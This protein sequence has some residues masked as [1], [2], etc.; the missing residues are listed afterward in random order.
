YAGH[1][2]HPDR[3]AAIRAA[4]TYAV[5]HPDEQIVVRP[6]QFRFAG[7][8]GMEIP[9]P[10]FNDIMERLQET[11]GLEGEQLREAMQGVIRPTSRRRWAGFKQQRKGVEGYS[12]DLD[13][14]MRAHLGEVVRYVYMDKIKYEAVTL[15]ERLGLT[16]DNRQ[17]KGLSAA[18]EAYVR[19]LL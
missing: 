3:G 9:G 2:F 1:G 10:R 11:F 17:R 16:P 4:R 13:R 19:D 5:T 18:F 6:T 14:V 7:P 12:R 8:G 15:R